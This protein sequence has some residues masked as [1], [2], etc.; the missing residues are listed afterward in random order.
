[1][2]KLIPQR[3]PQIFIQLRKKNV[4]LDQDI[5]AKHLSF[6]YKMRH[7]FYYKI[8][9]FNYKMQQGLQ[10]APILLQNAA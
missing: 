2:R 5:I 3:Y 1:M 9:Q 6:Y 4:Y 7:V 10:N 8:C